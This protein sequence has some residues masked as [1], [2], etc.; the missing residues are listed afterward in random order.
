MPCW[1]KS[2]AS[3][4]AVRSIADQACRRTATQ[5]RPARRRGSRGTDDGSCPRPAG[6]R[7][8]LVWWS[9]YGSAVKTTLDIDE[10]LMRAALERARSTGV[11]LTALISDALRR[12]L[13]EPAPAEFRLDLPITNG[14]R[15]PTV[16]MDSSAALV[17][18]FDGVEQRRSAS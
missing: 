4:T 7:I 17:E 14:R 10:D 5:R 9:A 3:D 2:F 15:M 18:Y 8:W 13:G 16:D 1:S 12:A 6:R 11:T